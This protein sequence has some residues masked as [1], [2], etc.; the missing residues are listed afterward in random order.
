VTGIKL[1]AACRP[2]VPANVNNCDICLFAIVLKHAGTEDTRTRAAR[3]ATGRKMSG[4][5]GNMSVATVTEIST[6][7]QKSFKDAI[8]KGFDQANNMLTDIEGA[9][10]KQMKVVVKGG[11][12]QEYRV[13]MK[14]TS[15][16]Q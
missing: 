1:Y 6:A 4:T 13:N 5:G 7:S 3:A 10:V 12:V 11:R 15:V 2:F 9:W 14:L 8:N 16:V